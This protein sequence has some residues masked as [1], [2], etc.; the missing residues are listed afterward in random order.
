MKK[1]LHRIMFAVSLMAIFMF[2]TESEAATKETVLKGIYIED[3]SIGSM[4]EEEATEEVQKYIDEL[5][6]T[7]ITLVA[8]GGQE[9]IVTGSELGL[10]WANP[11]VIGEAVSV[12]KC[13]NVIQRYKQIKDLAHEDIHFEVLLDFDINAI[14]SVIVNQCTPHDRN[15]LD[16]RLRRVDD[17]FVVEEGQIGY[18]TDVEHSIDIVYDTLVKEWSNEGIRIELDITEDIPKG[19]T[20]ELMQVKDVL[21]TFTTSFSTSGSSRSGN[22]RNGCHLVDATTLYP[23]EEFSMLEKLLPFSTENGYFMAGSYL[24]GQVV[25]SLGGGI[26]Q[27]SSTLYNAVLKAELEVTERHNHSMIV[28]YV[29][30]AADAA[31][32]E[33]SGKNFRFVNNTDYPIYIEGI[34]TPNKRITFNIY[35]VET[36]DTVNREVIYESVILEVIHPDTEILYPDPAQGVGYIDEQSAHIGYK[37]QLWKVVKENGVEVERTQV[38]SSNY[39]V[40][41]RSAIVGVATD[42]PDIYNAMMEAIATNSVDHVKNVAAMFAPPVVVETPPAE[43][44]Q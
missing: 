43:V 23:G 17:E 36:R 41:P 2:A 14:N 21:G 16:Y 34:T 10:T 5:R 35:G 33:S 29:S 30:A 25:D 32:A 27:V 13:G 22:V 7:E 6:Q 31:I 19:S 9:V 37:A 12:G 28:N 4:T 3:V 18:V 44:T 20:E 39:K 8:A 40:S 42:N 1:F 15:A 11:E 24:N 38:N 26:C